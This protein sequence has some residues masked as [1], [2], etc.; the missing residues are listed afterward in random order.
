MIDFFGWQLPVWYKAK[1][2]N[3]EHLHVRECVGLFDVSHMGEILVTGP[4]ATAFLQRLTTNDVAKVAINQA[5]YTLM[6][7]PH[8][9]IVDDLILYKMAEDRY[10]LVVN[11]SNADKDFAWIQEQ[12][13][14]DV[15][16]DN[17]SAE[18]AQL[19]IQG[20]KAVA[21]LSTMIDR[22][23]LDDIGYYHFRVAPVCGVQTI[24]SRTGYTGEDGFE[25][26]F[27]KDQADL[28]W[29]TIM[30]KGKDFSL[31]PIGLGARDTLRMEMGFSLYGQEISDSISP[32]EAGLAWVVKLKKGDFI[33]RDALMAQKEQGIPRSIV[34]FEMLEPAMPRTHYKVFRGEEE[35]G[36]V[37]SGMKSPV[38]N[39]SIGMALIKKAYADLG[40]EIEIAIRDKK[41]KAKVV[42]R[43]FIKKG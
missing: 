13:S 22:R 24:I 1:G 14:G 32:L 9:G 8:G 4:D 5:Q 21:L 15:R 36:E 26:Y 30:T 27:S 6:C 3:F 16:A 17:L 10:F 40:S 33:G 31:E 28:F 38:L 19:A 34:A 12:L 7:Y 20:P 25:L 43:P 37:T 35:I 41:I 29:N 18:Y 39:T 2:M 42:N 23:L 11:A